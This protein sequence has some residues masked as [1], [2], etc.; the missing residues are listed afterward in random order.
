MTKT[1]STVGINCF[2]CKV[3]YLCL[4]SKIAEGALADF[5]EQLI[6]IKEVKKGESIFRAGDPLSN[7]YAVY[8]GSCKDFSI[9][10]DGTEVINNFYLGGDIIGLESIPNKKHWFSLKALEDAQLCVIPIEVIFSLIE[11]HPTLLMRFLHIF[12]YKMQNDYQVNISTNAQQRVAD[13]ILNIVLRMQER[14]IGLAYQLPMGQVD[15]SQFLGM[16]HE[17]VNRVLAKFRH[18]NIIDLNKKV[19]RVLDIELLK[20]LASPIIS[21]GQS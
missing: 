3:N 14:T 18:Q 8:Q 7:L 5:N 17:T 10:E 1:R 21:F 16:S 2:D 12:S 6:G 13:F 20:S 9:R 11:K 19:I 4:G 15:I